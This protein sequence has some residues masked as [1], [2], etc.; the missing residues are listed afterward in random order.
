MAMNSIGTNA[1]SI[2]IGACRLTASTTNARA[3]ARLYAG[4]TEAMAMTVFDSR[5]MA[6]SLRPLPS[7]PWP[8]AARWLFDDAGHK[9]GSPS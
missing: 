5:P 6:P 4:A 9:L 2:T 8:R 7:S 3:A 1:S